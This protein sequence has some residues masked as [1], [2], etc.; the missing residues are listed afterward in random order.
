M[1]LPVIIDAEN[2]E[3]EKYRNLLDSIIPFPEQ[4]DFTEELNPDL[5]GFFR[6]SKAQT[7]ARFYLYNF[8]IN[9]DR[10]TKTILNIAAPSMFEAYIDG[11]KEAAKT[12]TEESLSA[13]KVMR[14]SFATAPGTYTVLLKYMSLPSNKSPEGIKITV[15]PGDKN[16]AVNY[17]F[18]N[19]L[20]R[21]ISITDMLLGTR[22]TDISISPNGQYV[23]LSYFTVKSDGRHQ[24]TKEIF[25]LKTNKKITLPENKNYKWM[26]VTNKLY[27]TDESQGTLKLKILD[28]ETREEKTLADS[29]PPGYFEF[30][31][32]ETFL[33]Y[34]D[35]EPSDSNK[36]DFILLFSPE[37]R[38]PNNKGKYSLS[39][40][41]L[42]T[43]TRQQ[44]TFVK[45]SVILNDISRDSRYLLY[46]VTEYTP[47]IR[48]FYVHSMY[49]MDLST[50][51][52]ET[53]WT[54]EGFAGFASFS[55]DGKDI[56]IEGS[57]EAFNGIGNSLQAGETPNFYN[58]QVFIMNLNTKNIQAITREFA[59]S[60]D[61][62]FWNP[63]DGMIYLKVTDK[64]FQ[65]IYRYDLRQKQ[66]KQLPLSEDVVRSVSYS[67][68]NAQAAYYGVGVSNST[69]AYVLDLKNDRSAIISD[70]YKDNLEKLN[71][72]QVEDWHFTSSG[73]SEIDG[74][75]Y[76]PPNFNPAQKYPLIVHYYGGMQPVLRRFEAPFPLH[77]YAALGYV[78]YVIQ[79]SGTVGYGAEFAARHVN[80]WGKPAADE[81]IEGTKKFISEHNFVNRE[82]VG[83]IGASYGG[84]LTMYMQTQIDIFTTAVSH[85]GISSIASY[86]GQ[87]YSGYT[88]GAA[89][90]ANNYP[91]N[92]KEMY[93]DQS[94]IYNADKINTPLLLL[95]GTE[96]TNVPI[97]ESMQMFTALKILGKPV[98]FIQVKGEGHGVRDYSKR[99]KWNNTI[100]AWFAKWL[101]DDSAWWNSMY[102][103]DRN[104]K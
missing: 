91:W 57:A 97:G 101:Q 84:F 52:V 67:N 86:W 12:T 73:G 58:K 36:G 74:Y 87:G 76:L 65:R 90:S 33:V 63:S 59:P 71:L 46:S 66:F 50:K 23:L 34:S 62:S 56:L 104:N 70:P 54:K 103:S 32:N 78:V 6:M 41:D 51:Q 16:G 72:G 100:C 20:K 55:P 53:L 81:I 11:K 47:T 94:P 69:R 39:K 77:V 85:A 15:E 9:V 1:D 45:E 13:A 61:A 27:F 19:T 37:D 95:H 3:G 93:V 83:C 30:A 49:K 40:Y 44:L 48:P 22:L 80:G 26:P 10:Y 18:D 98:E 75:Y 24:E 42:S 17:S 5:S 38:F 68:S 14:L 102:S 2:P 79:P 21:N 7:G 4:K 89:A 88:Y 64:N 99:I 25:V 96:D 31:P 8:N 28:P 60:V 29:I 92:N 43:R 82:K 35:W